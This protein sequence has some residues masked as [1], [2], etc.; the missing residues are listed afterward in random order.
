[1]IIQQ[2]ISA[3][4]ISLYTFCVIKLLYIINFNLIFATPVTSKAVYWFRSVIFWYQIIL[5]YT[6]QKYFSKQKYW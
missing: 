1:M 5:A 6:L 3:N 4:L 2:L